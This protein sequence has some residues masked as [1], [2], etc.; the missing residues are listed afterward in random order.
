MCLSSSAPS[1]PRLCWKWF[2]ASTHSLQ[3]IV[4]GLRVYIQPPLPILLVHGQWLTGA[5]RSQLLNLKVQQQSPS[6]QSYQ[7]SWHY[8]DDLACF[9]FLEC[10]IDSSLAVLALGCRTWAFSNCGQ[11]GLVLPQGTGWRCSGSSGCGARVPEHSLSSCG[12]RALV[13][14]VGS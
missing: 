3:R 9:L 4:L 5:E 12:P 11:R 14:L 7:A 1:C 10:I 13:A 6:L 2:M 8:K